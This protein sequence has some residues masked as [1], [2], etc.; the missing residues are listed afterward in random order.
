MNW[1]LTILIM[2]IKEYIIGLF[3]KYEK[4][5][6][7]EILEQKKEKLN[8]LTTKDSAIDSELDSALTKYRSKPKPG[9]EV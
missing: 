2:W 4:D 8:D 9:D 1:L 3:Q 7:I 5:V 6:K